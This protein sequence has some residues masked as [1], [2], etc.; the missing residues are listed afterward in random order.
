[1]PADLVAVMLAALAGLL[2]P[3]APRADPRRLVPTSRRDEVPGPS[4]GPTDSLSRDVALPMWVPRTVG[5]AAGLAVLTGHGA[6]ATVLAVATAA[7][8]A[9]GVRAAAERR[10]RSAT[11]ARELPR[12]ADLLAACLQAG[13]PLPSAVGEVGRVVDEVTAR[14]LRGLVIGASS[15]SFTHGPEGHG[16]GSSSQRRSPASGLA[17][18]PADSWARL[19]RAVGRATERGAPLADVL[20]ALA[21][22][23][24]DRARW[25]AEEAV[26]RVGVRSVGPLAACFLPAF[27]LVGV[28][29]VVVGVAGAVLGDLR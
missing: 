3:H 24:R 25:A 18:D 9:P 5:A 16:S 11:T 15:R 14:R 4:T 2:L 26:R 20:A 28:V 6:A 22:D 10:R 29:P 23:E 12:V 27:V 7:L 1:M 19:E 8:A 17:S 21:A 13:L